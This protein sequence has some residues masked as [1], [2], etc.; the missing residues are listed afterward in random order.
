M[1]S[2][3]PMTV[4][5]IDHPERPGRTLQVRVRKSEADAYKARRARSEPTIQEAPESEP[6]PEPDDSDKKATQHGS[7]R[8]QKQEDK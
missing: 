4:I 5:E 6:E 7:K 1:A 8:R 2:N 3:D